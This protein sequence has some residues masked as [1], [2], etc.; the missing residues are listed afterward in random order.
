MKPLFKRNQK[1]L[2]LNKFKYQPHKDQVQKY[3]KENEYLILTNLDTT[4]LFNRDAI[5]DYEPF[6]ELKFIDLLTQF[7]TIDNLWDTVR[8]LDDKKIKPELESEFFTDLKKWYKHFDTVAFDLK[9]G[10]SKEELI[11]LFLNKIIFIKT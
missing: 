8:R 7:L 2:T 4:Y 5:I 6:Y 1:K 10:F 11:V 9:D 3:L